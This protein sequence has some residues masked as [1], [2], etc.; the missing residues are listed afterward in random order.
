MSNDV[1]D[2]NVRGRTFVA[3]VRSGAQEAENR[4]ELAQLARA[5]PGDVVQVA[6]VWRP[7]E[8]AA[9]VGTPTNR[10][11]ATV[12]R[13][14][15]LIVL[16]LPAT[17]AL[18]W[19]LKVSGWWLLPLWALLAVAAYLLIVWL[20]LVHNSPASTERHRINKAAHLKGLELRLNHE[21]RRAIVQAYLDRFEQ[22]E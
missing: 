11:A 7:T 22:D 13:A 17:A 21:L 8:A 15:P 10:A 20:D 9:E 4:R 1:P 2:E 5:E 12:I 19:L 16:L 18:V 6:E 14:A 3:P